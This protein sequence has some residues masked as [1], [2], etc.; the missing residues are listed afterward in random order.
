MGAIDKIKQEAAKEKLREVVA[1]HTE[2]LPNVF[3]DIEAFYKE[4]GEPTSVD[5]ILEAIVVFQLAYMQYTNIKHSKELMQIIL[6]SFQKN[7]ITGLD[8]LAILIGLMQ[9]AVYTPIQASDSEERK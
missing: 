2:K 6:K 5:D 4:K 3:A 9:M 8:Q 7:N 1:K